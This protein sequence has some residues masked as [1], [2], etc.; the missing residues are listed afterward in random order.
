MRFAYLA[1]AGSNALSIGSAILITSSPGLAQQN[2]GVAETVAQSSRSE[3]P[4]AAPEREPI[5]VVVHSDTPSLGATQIREAVAQELGQQVLGPED[6]RAGSL[7]RRLTISHRASRRELAVSYSD[8]SRGNWTRVIES[9]ESIS[10]V[11]SASALLAGNLVRTEADSLL[12]PAP[13]APPPA[14]PDPLPPGNNRN[15]TGFAPTELASGGPP[16]P[17]SPRPQ[18]LASAAF[19]Y[20]LATNYGQPEIETNFEFNLLYGRVGKL[21]GVGIGSVNVASDSVRGLS[22]GLANVVGHSVGGLQLAGLFNLSGESVQGLQV[23]AGLNVARGPLEGIQASAIGNFA[24]APSS[25]AQLAFGINHAPAFEGLQVAGVANLNL[26]YMQGVQVAPVFNYGG[27]IKG[28]QLGLVN[29]AKRVRGAQ[30]GL[31]NVAD[32]VEGAP[33]GLVSVTRTGG[34]HPQVWAA[35]SSYFNAALKF[36]T[37]YTYTFLSFSV[38][39]NDG[40]RLQGPGF[41]VGFTVP[42][43]PRLF[44]DTDLSGTHLF[45]KGACCGESFFSSVSRERDWT[46]FRLR[47][48]LRYEFLPH[49]SVFAGGALGARLT[50]PLDEDDND[51]RGRSLLEGHAG[52]QL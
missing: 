19:F 6:P 36:A 49:L 40:H 20:P 45:G 44:F 34:I 47:A 5:V 10:D 35:S 23:A 52:V 11:V 43:I 50:Y 31:I 42:A 18:Q 24:G 37:R 22:I 3:S 32:D 33:I 14:P 28:L 27:N 9:P 1:L 38:H 8:P 17:E 16:G 21:E 7:S 30:V 12:P 46:L 48:H 2:R 25:G 15:S 39:E 13:P 51:I 4:R 29:V 41:G 26:G